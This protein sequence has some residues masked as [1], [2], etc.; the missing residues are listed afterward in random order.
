MKVVINI[1]ANGLNPTQIWCAVAKDLATGEVHVFRKLTEASGDQDAF[2]VFMEG[3]EELVGHNLLGYD[4]PVIR[5]L[6]PCRLPVVG[7]ATCDTLIISKM[8][9]YSR[10]GHST[11]HYAEEF[12]IDKPKQ[13]PYKVYSEELVD[14]CKILVDITEKI[15]VK[16]KRYIHNPDYSSAIALEHSF[17]CVVNALHNNG[18]AFNTQRAN[19]LL[20]KVTSELEVLDK[21]ILDAFPPREILIREFTPT[22]T[23][24][25]TISKSSI[26]VSLRGAVH[27]FEAGRTYRHTKH[28]DFNPAS[29]KQLIQVLNEAGWSPTDKTQ[30]HI[31][32]ER[33]LTRLKR[34]SKGDPAVDVELSMLYDA[35]SKLK[36]S[37]WKINEQNLSTLPATSPPSARL[38]AQRILLESR[39]RSLTEWLKLVAEDGR[40]HGDFYGLG[41]WTHRMAHQ[42]PN[43]ANIPNEFREDGSTKL[44]GKE[45]RS[46]WCAPRNRLLVGVDAEGIQL[47]IF[48]HYIQD[49]EFTDALV[50]GRKEDKSDPHS[51]NQ[52]ILGSVCKSRQAAKRFIYALLL[53]AGL[54]KLAQILGCSEAEAREAL[55][56]LLER[57]TG[58]AFLKAEV[59]PKDARR[60]WFIG[61]DGRP[62]R[63]PGDTEGSKRHLA[64]SGYLQN[65]EAIVVKKT[66]LKTLDKIREE[67]L[68]AI[69]VNVV[70]DEVIFEI[71]NNV[72]HGEHVSDLFCRSIEETGI[73]LNLKS[74][75][76][77]D[78]HVGLNWYE[79]H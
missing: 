52:R 36:I 56:R 3:V 18:F 46:L 2:K 37:G 44:L 32:K 34:Q 69:L 20:A 61:L 27:T 77:G 62:V 75:L 53:G 30:T 7:P 70:H 22:L 43:T 60:G 38:L 4:Y 1:E 14:Y 54:P 48:A 33:E 49:Q 41:A 74:P 19:K 66:V 9:D 55:N 16:Y 5:R 29:H 21:G 23:K 51:L 59:I 24:H 6:V 17:Q 39:R 31:D 68:D 26:P 76:A 8:V 73:E 63:I 42:R 11:S 13:P 47:R 12:G 57:Y 78:G 50:R 58:F 28:E 40:I 35:I 10:K 79:I 64:M 67:E 15:Y 45:M 25:G 72:R 71:P 65:G